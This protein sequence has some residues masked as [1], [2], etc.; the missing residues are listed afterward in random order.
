MLAEKICLSAQP[1]RSSKSS[2][3]AAKRNQQNRTFAVLPRACHRLLR[4]RSAATHT[5]T[6]SNQNFQTAKHPIR[7]EAHQLTTSSSYR[8][9]RQTAKWATDHHCH[10]HHVFDSDTRRGRNSR[11]IPQNG[12]HRRTCRHTQSWRASPQQSAEVNF[13]LLLL[14]ARRNFFFFFAQR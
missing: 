2:S 13:H 4:H 7:K 5:S 12:H 1:K 14:P 6:K 3:I 10:Y 8:R 11:P 9:R